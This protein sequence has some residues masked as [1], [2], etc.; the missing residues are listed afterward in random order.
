NRVKHLLKGKNLP[1]EP[2]NIRSKE[3]DT[4]DEIPFVIHNPK[5]VQK[6]FAHAGLKVVKVRS[7][8][9]TR[10][11]GLKKVM[12]R[13]VL[14]VAERILQPTLAKT[15]FGPSVFFLVKKAK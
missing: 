4:D 7:V 3:H 12:P 15:Y 9:Y 13:G 10:S 11:P 1:Q 2:V 6:Q 14:L 5:T 8:T